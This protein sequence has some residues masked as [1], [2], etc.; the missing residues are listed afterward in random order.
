LGYQIVW[1]WTRR[2]QRTD[3]VTVVGG[4]G[5][6]WFR[7]FFPAGDLGPSTLRG[8]E[9]VWYFRSGP[10]ANDDVGRLLI[11]RGYRLSRVVVDDSYQLVLYNR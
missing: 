6:P 11:E 9:R 5:L 7:T 1:D 4:A 3:Q 8:I 2:L 10:A